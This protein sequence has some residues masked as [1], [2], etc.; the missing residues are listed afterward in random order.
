MGRPFGPERTTDRRGR[1]T[2]PVALSDRSP[3]SAQQWARPDLGARA[4]GDIRPP[5]N[6]RLAKKVSRMRHMLFATY[7]IKHF[8]IHIFFA[9]RSFFLPFVVR[10]RP[11]FGTNATEESF[12]SCG[13]FSVVHGYV[14]CTGLR[15]RSISRQPTPR[16]NASRRIGCVATHPVR[17]DALIRG[18]GVVDISLKSCMGLMVTRGRVRGGVRQEPP[19]KHI[20][21]FSRCSAGGKTFLILTVFGGRKHI[22]NSHGVR[23]EE[24]H[25]YFSRCSAGGKTFLILAVF[26]RSPHRNK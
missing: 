26:G 1:P 22:F 15:S 8:F 6:E 5:K 16:I 24:K 21:Y 11:H 9:I 20:V 4:E 19:Q 2:R 10:T 14:L 7:T 25:F 18:V 17:L 13:S 23:R 12:R 3:F